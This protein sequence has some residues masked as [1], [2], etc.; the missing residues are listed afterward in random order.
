MT[1]SSKYKYSIATCA[2]V[3]FVDNLPWDQIKT[4]AITAHEHF[5]GDIVLFCYRAPDK[6]LL[7]KQC[8]NLGID[9]QYVT[10]D[11]DGRLLSFDNPRG[12]SNCHYLRHFKLSEFIDSLNGKY[13][14]TIMTD[15]RDVYFQSDPCEWLI[16][17]LKCPLLFS[18]EQLNYK[19]ESWGWT[20][21][22]SVYGQYLVD[23]GLA[24]W[25][26]FNSGVVAGHSNYVSML[27]KLVY[28]LCPNRHHPPDQAT[29]N[30]LYHTMLKYM[31]QSGSDY[32]GCSI[33][34]C[35][36]AQHGD[37]WA[38]QCG[39]TL[40]PSKSHYKQA[41][42][43]SSNNTPVIKI[44]NVNGKDIPRVQTVDGRLFSIVHQWDRVPVL[45]NYMEGLLNDK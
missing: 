26:I 28:E 40:D 35:Q 36:S 14:Y 15:V 23:R 13:D 7:K 19:D 4:W 41:L 18:S 32:E 34:L 5:S 12:L 44:E 45:K 22:I 25:E 17:N 8:D 11:S 29:Y 9:L 30:F 42:L 31:N 33:P 24:E 1:Y 27:S 10:T 38:C 39:T 6:E 37:G 43:G 20:N 2:L 16:E 3:G 21:I